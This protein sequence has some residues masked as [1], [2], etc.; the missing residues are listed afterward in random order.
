MRPISIK[1]MSIIGLMVTLFI[2]AGCGNSDLLDEEELRYSLAVESSD[3]DELTDE[4]DVVRADCDDDGGATGLLFPFEAEVTVSSYVS[5]LSESDGSPPAEFV[6]E[7]YE[8]YLDPV[9]GSYFAG[10]EEIL[11]TKDVMPNLNA[12]GFTS[13]TRGRRGTSSS[14]VTPGSSVT[15]DLAIWSAGDKDAYLTLLSN[16]D[17]LTNAGAAAAGAL[18]SY[19]LRVVVHCRSNED[20]DFTIEGSTPVFFGNYLVDSECVSE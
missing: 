8:Y 17:L 20:N 1:L 2:F 15:L 10:G 18:F 13:S 11:V 16:F 14:V 6:V 9:S 3:V 7:S 12:E 4:I 19:D 5:D